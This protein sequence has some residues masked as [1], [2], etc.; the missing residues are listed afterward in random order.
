MRLFGHLLRGACCLTI[1]WS[2][3]SWGAWRAGL[4]HELGLLYW[5]V[6]GGLAAALVATAVPI[7]ARA[8]GADERVHSGISPTL[9]A[10]ALTASV[11]LYQLLFPDYRE[12][13]ARAALGLG[14]AG[15]VLVDRLGKRLAT[16]AVRNR[17]AAGAFGICVA[18]WLGE[19]VLRVY[20]RVSDNPIFAPPAGTGGSALLRLK[21]YRPGTE[22][23]GFPVNSDGDYDR[24]R[25]DPGQ[26]RERAL[27]VS[28]AD[29]FTMMAT[30]WP[31]QFTTVCERALGD[32]EVCNVGTITIGLH[33]YLYLLREEALPLRPDA[34]VVNIFVGNDLDVPRTSDEATALQKLYDRGALALSRFAARYGAIETE[35]ARADREA[36]DVE[37]SAVSQQPVARLVDTPAIAHETYPFTL[38]VAL[39]H[40]TFSREGY[41]YIERKRAETSCNPRNDYEPFFDLVEQ[42]VREAGDIP[43]LFTLIPDEFQV[44]D[45]LWSEITQRSTLALERDRAQDLINAWC[46]ERGV[47]LLDLLPAFRAVAPLPDGR[48]HLY[49]A[50]DT[51]WNTRGAELAGNELARALAALLGR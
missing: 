47:A 30:P 16:P 8:G 39:E 50:R 29:S 38:D 13:Y 2:L 36:E 49:H 51:H 7:R 10:V 3:W 11:V 14:L 46:A 44:E 24:E 45:E 27:V 41:A 35:R 20:A 12:I 26:P 23:Y 15:A 43:L 19:G 34:I 32:V 25:P 1:G 22:Y 9:C 28:I 40:P 6:A 21:R 42:I 17:A 4:R 18:L 33:E 37:A 48:R 31:L 5:L